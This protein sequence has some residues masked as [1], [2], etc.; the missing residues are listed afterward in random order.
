[1][2]AFTILKR[3]R[4]RTDTTSLK[5]L[6]ITQDSTALSKVTSTT[7]QPQKILS[8]HMQGKYIPPV[9]LILKYKHSRP[10]PNHNYGC[11]IVFDHILVHIHTV[12]F[13]D[14]VSKNIFSEVHPLY[15]H[16]YK[17]LQT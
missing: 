16:L 11:E 6:P 7:P 9:S 3:K 13:L 8:T 15:L 5:K 1:M 17:C 10:N 14:T 12:G 4:K 2:V